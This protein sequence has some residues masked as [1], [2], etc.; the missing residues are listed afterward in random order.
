MLKSSASANIIILNVLNIDTSATVVQF[1]LIFWDKEHFFSPVFSIVCFV[2][3]INFIRNKSKG[4]L[5]RRPINVSR[6]LQCFFY[7]FGRPH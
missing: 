2:A 5:F 7:L 3:L 6:N 4:F 1:Q